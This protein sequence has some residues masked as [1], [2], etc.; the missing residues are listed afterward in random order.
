MQKN[1]SAATVS[2]LPQVLDKIQFS[3]DIFLPLLEN[4][5]S[6]SSAILIKR[7]N[8]YRVVCAN[9]ASACV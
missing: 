1:C 2:R 8:F 4:S 3:S 9:R 6:F 7:E 5:L